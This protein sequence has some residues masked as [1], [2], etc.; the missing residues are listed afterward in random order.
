MGHQG[1]GYRNGNT[2]KSQRIENK[3]HG[4]IKWTP[5][6]EG[7]VPFMAMSRGSIPPTRQSPGII[8]FTVPTEKWAGDDLNLRSPIC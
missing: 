2:Y 1:Q 5:S 3:K 4:S 7:G 8:R 6:P